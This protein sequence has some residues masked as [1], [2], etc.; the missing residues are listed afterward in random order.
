MEQEDFL[1]ELGRRGFI[2]RIRRINELM[3]YDTIDYYTTRNI[4]IKQ[5]WHLIFL[6][7]KKEEVLTISDI[8][9]RLQFSHPAIIK[10]IKGM[11]NKGYVA[12]RKDPLD[13]RRQLIQLT[14]KAKKELPRFEFEWNVIESVI[15]QSID[16]DIFEA[17]AKLEQIIMEKSIGKRCLEYLALNEN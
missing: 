15:A 10:I 12:F 17:L 13:A 1:K 11:K 9:R 6:L 8:S 3:A 16:Q 2:A 4:G 7:L 5:N 14:P